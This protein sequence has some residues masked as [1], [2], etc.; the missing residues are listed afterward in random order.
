MAEGERGLGEEG[1]LAAQ[2]AALLCLLSLDWLLLLGNIQL[3]NTDYLSFQSRR[4]AA[5]RMVEA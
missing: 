5:N 3:H 2:A 4:R 1:G